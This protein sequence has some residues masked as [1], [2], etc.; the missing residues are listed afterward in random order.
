MSRPV[1]RAAVMLW[2][3]FAAACGGGGGNGAAPAAPTIS[4]VTVACVPAQIE[5]GQSSQCTATVT[6]T[7]S[8]S[9]AVTWSTNVGA[10]SASGLFSAP[11]APAAAIVTA[12]SVQDASRSGTDSV[13]VSI[14]RATADLADD[15]PVNVHVLYVVPADGTDHQYD[16]D[17]TLWT[18]LASW[19][20]WFSGQA[21]GLQVRLDTYNGRPDITFVRLHRTRS[22]MDSFGL[23]TRDQIEYE[24]LAMGFDD[25]EKIYLVYYDGGGP[26]TTACGGGPHPP[27]LPGSVA[28]LYLQGQPV[29]APPCASNAF[30]T[31]PALPGYLEFGAIHEIVHTLGFAPSCAPNVT[32]VSHVSDS[33]TDLMYA[34]PMAWAPSVL[35]F[36]HDDYFG[37]DIP[38]CIDLARST[39][40]DPLPTPNADW[41][42]GWPYVNLDALDCA[43]ESA[44][45]SP[46]SAT[47]ATTVEFVNGTAAPSRVYWLDGSAVRHLYAT[48]D[49]YEGYIQA[50]FTAHK[51]VVTDLLDQC[52][53]VYDADAAH[54]RAI[55][56]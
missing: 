10:V 20:E 45:S 34:G 1:L 17:G 50:T 40:L 53:A 33:N 47:P 16:T 12:T 22:E 6:G 37:A 46:T 5:P 51:W 35:D 54:G 56:K 7:G 30:A 27:D 41:P 19:R 18:S 32:A 3:A 44:S 24:L 4:A 55:T 49:P 8:Y 25:P 38:G 39:F 11:D 14:P 29:G 31:D 28:A 36:N 21:S 2:S 26:G 23:H 15:A 43:Q 42:P 52:L 13:D 48:L 9:S